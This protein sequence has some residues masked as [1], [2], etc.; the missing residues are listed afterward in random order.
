MKGT[1]PPPNMML[2]GVL[3]SICS[4]K[5]LSILHRARKLLISSEQCSFFHVWAVSPTWCFSS[6]SS[7]IK[8]IWPMTYSCCGDLCGSS[9]GA[10]RLLAAS[11]INSLLVTLAGRP[12][13][14]LC[15]FHFWMNGPFFVFLSLRNA[16][17]FTSNKPQ[18]TFSDGM[19]LDGREYLAVHV[20]AKNSHRQKQCIRLI[21]Q[22]LKNCTGK[23]FEYSILTPI[24][25]GRM[26][27][28]H[29]SPKGCPYS[30]P[31]PARPFLM[32]RKSHPRRPLLN[33]LLKASAD[34]L[35]A[36]S[37]PPKKHLGK[38]ERVSVQPGADA[39][40]LSPH[41]KKL[42]SCYLG[43]ALHLNGS[44][45][46]QELPWPRKTPEAEPSLDNLTFKKKRCRSV[47]SFTCAFTCFAT[48]SSR[49]T[50]SVWGKYP[51]FGIILSS[52]DTSV[53]HNCVY[54]PISIH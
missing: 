46:A 7:S 30:L 42:S 47:T 20:R 18:H 25:C 52:N 16:V 22:M 12:L 14:V 43:R 15:A 33:A 31:F 51:H 35:A 50:P 11:L 27:R 54:S 10:L 26:D 19:L 45:F 13:L 41:K 28:S 32:S 17:L 39:A 53:S 38:E 36:A 48:R 23:S 21:S 2:E 34:R 9:T 1:P 37:R 49:Q 8:V 29:R 3:S 6:C 40:M 24:P 5:R 4:V 44:V